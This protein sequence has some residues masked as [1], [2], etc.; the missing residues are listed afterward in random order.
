[1]RVP[2]AVGLNSMELVQLEPAGS[3][4]GQVEADLMKELAFAPEI[5]LDALK[6]TGV[7]PVFLM[8]IVWAAV[9]VPTGVEANV[10]GLGVNISVGPAEAPVPV[11]GTV[12][13]L[14]VAVSV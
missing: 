14:P 3:G 9:V 11:R 1:V 10:N 13:G 7:A 12:C 8:V 6:V 2:E 4:L 5:V